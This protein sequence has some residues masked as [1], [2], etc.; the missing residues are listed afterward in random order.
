MKFFGHFVSKILITKIQWIIAHE[1]LKNLRLLAL[2]SF[3]LENAPVIPA[4]RTRYIVNIFTDVHEKFWP[5]RFENS[6]S[7]EVVITHENRLNLR[8]PAFRLI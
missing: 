5:F 8:L 3:E 1:N 4:G 2:D 7:Q 6:E